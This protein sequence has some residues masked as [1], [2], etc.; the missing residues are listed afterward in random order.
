M[1]LRVLAGTADNVR[2]PPRVRI[3]MASLTDWKNPLP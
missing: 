3:V 2:T 1:A